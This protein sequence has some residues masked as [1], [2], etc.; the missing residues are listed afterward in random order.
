[1]GRAALGSDW[2]GWLL[3]FPHDLH[4]LGWHYVE[5]WPWATSFPFLF[6]IALWGLTHGCWCE[7]SGMSRLDSRG[8]RHL[9][10]L[11]F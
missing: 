6:G 3:S 1:V 7:K 10:A 5:K 2:A 8:L 9:A 11:S 4:G